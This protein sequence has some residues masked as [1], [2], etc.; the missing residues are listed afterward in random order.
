M[1][2]AEIRAVVVAIAIAITSILLAGCDGAIDTGSGSQDSGATSPDAW[3][4]GNDV[5]PTVVDGPIVTVTDGPG[6][7]HDGIKDGGAQAPGTWIT[8]PAGGFMMGSPASEPCRAMLTGKETLH[9][10]TL[11]RSFKISRTEVTQGQF[12]TLMGF[13]PS[14]F[15]TAG[16]CA[17][18]DCP[19][20]SVGWN[21]AVQY[22]N[23]LSKQAGLT[24]C[25]TCSGSAT[26]KT[27]SPVAAFAGPK[28]YEC[29]GYRL[30]TEAEWEYAY[31]AG[32][33]TAYHS[34]P[35]DP[36]KCDGCS[37]GE[38]SLDPIGWYCGNSGDRTHP[39]GQKQPNK[40]GLLDMSG[41]VFEWCHDWYV[42]D[43]GSAADKDPAGPSSGTYRVLR[44]GSH[45]SFN[46]DTRAATR[47]GDKPFQQYDS[48][49]FRC[50]RTE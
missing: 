48:Y 40:W 27:C 20:E 18:A 49:G 32:T 43:L 24:P 19:V 5:N 2:L 35:K 37:P 44:G 12:S 42:E 4:P 6:S 7:A 8:I 25:Y 28:I 13:N 23:A 34:G 45:A 11:T 14:A 9:Q 47:R 22:C 30:P 15:A 38:A 41:N 29:P 26:I 39:V 10:V 17:S 1:N 21:E 3:V 31:R 46:R 33:S 50:V 16:K 36:V